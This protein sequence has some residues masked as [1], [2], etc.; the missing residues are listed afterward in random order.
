M[1]T[2]QLV[3][4]P[5]PVA[6][7]SVV[8]N[9]SVSGIAKIQ[10]EAR[11]PFSLATNSVGPHALRRLRAYHR[12]CALGLLQA[13]FLGRL[14]ACHPVVV[15][16]AWAQFLGHSVPATFHF[17]WQR[18]SCEMQFSYQTHSARYVDRSWWVPKA[19][20]RIGTVWFI[21]CPKRTSFVHASSINPAWD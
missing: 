21:L 2:R 6:A 1:P 7:A 20:G 3:S 12:S 15:L 11:I 5:L 9:Y 8:A 4:E 17:F 13:Q 10:V 14:R 19:A 18:Q 16:L